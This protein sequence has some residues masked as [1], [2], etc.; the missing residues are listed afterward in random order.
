MSLFRVHMIM[1][2]CLQVFS[3]V[4]SMPGHGGRA[5]SLKLIHACGGLVLNRAAVKNHSLFDSGKYRCEATLDLHLL[6][7][8]Y[9]NFLMFQLVETQYVKYVKVIYYSS[10]TSA[11]LLMQ[12]TPSRLTQ[13]QNKLLACLSL[14]VSPE[15][16]CSLRRHQVSLSVSCPTSGRQHRLKDNRFAQHTQTRTHLHACI[17]KG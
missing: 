2:D 10:L 8:I 6:V 12:L 11:V 7:S 15:R 13:M 1:V 14:L 4:L 3:D 5:Q 17:H 16:G 9:F